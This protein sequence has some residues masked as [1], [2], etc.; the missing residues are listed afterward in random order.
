MVAMDE[1]ALGWFQWWESWNPNH[2]W[3]GFKIAISQRFQASNLG[4]P[5]QALLALEQEKAVQEFIGQFEKHVGMVKGLEEPFLVKVFLK[6]LKEEINTK[7]RLYEPKNLMESMV[8]A[9]KEPWKGNKSNTATKNQE[10]VIVEGSESSKGKT[11]C[12][13]SQ[14]SNYNNNKEW[15]LDKRK[16]KCYN[17]QKLGHYAKEFWHGEGAKNKLNNHANLAQDEGSDS[18]LVLLMATISSESSSD[19]SWYLDSGCST[20]MTRKRDWFINLNKSSKS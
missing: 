4:N 12:Q 10:Q 14:K 3:E 13:T 9:W 1:E 5:F 6:G 16:V 18:E 17:C 7:V 8:K 20:H 15:K 2:S 19:F 11:T